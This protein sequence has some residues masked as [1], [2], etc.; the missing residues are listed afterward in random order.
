M[1][2]SPSA[3][4]KGTRR[5]T[6]PKGKQMAQAVAEEMGGGMGEEG[7]E[8]AGEAGAQQEYALC[9]LKMQP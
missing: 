1:G 7:V 4:P 5:T 8:D 3:L 9:S 2:D 6:C